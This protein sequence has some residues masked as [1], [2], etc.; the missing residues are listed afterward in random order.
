VAVRTN[1]DP[2]AAF[3]P[4]VMT[5]SD[6]KAVVDVK[7]PD[8]LTRYRVVAI[9]VAGERNFG[10]G[11]SAV[12]ARM[13]LMVRPSPPRFLNFGDRFELPVVVQNQTDAPM[14]V[15]VAVRATN[16]TL[17]D[18]AGR[19]VQ[20]PAQDRVEVRFPAAADLAGTARFQMV[21]S[22][23]RFSDAAELALPVWTPATTEAFATY[24]VID[25]GAIR[26]P[27]A[28]P[29]KVV[30]AYGGLEVETSSTQLQ[31]LTDAFLYLVTYPFECSEQIS[32]R[33]LGI[34][35]LKDV[36]T[37]FKAEGL[38]P[39]AEIEARVD[40]DLR[41]LENMQNW[42]GG[43][44]FWQRGYESWPFLSVHVANA[45]VRAKQKGF[46]VDAE[47]L[48]RSQ[49][50]L[51]NIERYYPWYYSED[52]KRTITSYA[53]YVRKL[54][55]D[56]DVAR[57]KG[58]IKEAGGVS[59]LSMEAVGWLLGVVAGDASAATERKD[60]L[61][62]LDN[63]AVETAGAANWTT[64]YADGAYLLLASDRRVDA[65]I[66][67][68]LIQEAHDNDLIPKVVTGLLAHK[69][70]GHWLNTQENV[71]VLLALD[72]YFHEYE[73]VTPDFVSKVWLGDGYAG[74]HTFQGR[75]TDR[76]QLDIPMKA[77]ADLP[78]GK[79][80]LTIQKA[81]KGRLYYRVGMSYAPADLKLAPADHGF[82]VDRVYEAVDD[83]ADVTR[84]ADGV[85][86]VKAGAR[87]RV[88]LTMVAESRRYHVA[89]VDPLP[90]GLEPMN[91]ALA[92]TG[93]V[94][95]DPNQQQNQGRYWWWSRTWYEHQNLRDERVEA[96]TSLLWEGIYDY[97]YVAR[98]TTPGTFVVPPTKAEE[99]YMPE[100]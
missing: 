58:L 52:V 42:D 83:P 28:L 59:K 57:A 89:L 30:E 22:A 3:A 34:A 10:K 91:P 26:Q 29:T 2:L 56:K 95:Q 82:V 53:L 35:A 1:F 100:T 68:S 75:Q 38:P 5:S 80:D 48:R 96:F 44:P 12:T 17:T 49:N 20:V 92:V 27:I 45:L 31:A 36:L 73:K 40:E 21:A 74:D 19:Q 47:M 14:T 8:N 93:P 32:S 77:V 65:V 54:M 71:F 25:S 98:A 55:G 18:G 13:P 64:S 7:M 23:G 33:V 99:M 16:A 6:G 37:A 51:Q 84:A 63:K 81:G 88:R 41:K 66:L 46:A 60:I 15:Q 86:H 97:T 85:W 78:G 43:F 50:Y 62:H 61:R 69:K 24:G 4:A 79:G 11:E 67:E 72:L 90:A 87:V 94:P 39:A 9:A 70:A 76:F